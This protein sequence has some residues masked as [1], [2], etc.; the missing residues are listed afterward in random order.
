MSSENTDA[1]DASAG[2]P[3]PALQAHVAFFDTDNDGILWPT[4]T[5]NGFQAIGFGLF[6]SVLSMLVIHSAFSYLTF[7]TLLPDPFFRIRISQ[8]KHAIHGSDTGI[9]TQTGELD[10]SRFNFVFDLYTAEP[11]MYMS[12]NEG[13]ALLRGNRNPF[14]VFGW[15]AAIIEWSS[16][17]L[18]LAEDGRVKR[19]DVHDIM[20]GTLFPKLAEKTNKKNE[21][22]ARLRAE[23]NKN[24]NEWES[25]KED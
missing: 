20:N 6:F 9:Y 13:L 7:G 8:I 10:E 17:Y 2:V 1:S 14:D 18:L 16:T 23:E 11:H 4:D 12:F 5:L 22:E 25:M 15:F 24:A 3:I 19:E 21:E